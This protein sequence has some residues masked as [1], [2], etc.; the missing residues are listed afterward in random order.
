MKAIALTFALLAAPVAAQTT[1]L[2]EDFSGGAFPPVGWGE[3]QTGNTNGWEGDTG[4][5]AFHDDFQDLSESLL[6]SASMDLSSAADCWLHLGFG[7]RYPD[8]RFINL[9]QATVDGGLTFVDIHPMA[10][11]T[12]GGGQ[13]VHL[14]LAAFTGNADVRLA[15]YY[16]GDNS[17]EWWLEHV[18]VDDQVPPPSTYWPVEPTGFLSVDSLNEDFETLAGVVPIWM[19][20]NNLDAATRQID[21]EA[22]C[23]IG[24][25]A[26]CSEAFSGSYSLELGLD[27]A[28]TGPH[29]V[30]NALI[31][32]L[33]GRGYTGMLLHFQ[34]KQFNE[35]WNPDDGVFISQNGDIWYP[36]ASGWSDLA[37]AGE[38]T[39]V[40]LDLG[41]TPVDLN[42]DF[43]VAFAEADNYPF[44]VHDGVAIDDVIAEPTGTTLHYS[45]SNV[46]GGQLANIDITGAY[47]PG[48][49]V[50]VFL[51]TSGPGPVNTPYGPALMT[52]PLKL[53]G[54]YQ[55]DPNGEIHETVG[56]PPR[57][58]GMTIW[59]QVI[60]AAGAE[61]SWS[62]ALEIIV[63]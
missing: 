3:F 10:S 59:T 38:W 58:T 13:M 41:Q 51:S 57:F 26:P 9:V 33:S 20:V 7:Q 4:V 44:G 53:V 55:P 21:A 12:S 47:R 1:Y 49:L 36:V 60:E 40:T 62:N 22:W 48:S 5:G 19:G 15:F 31:M 28:V 37:P 32:G 16:E 17:N 30:S 6:V 27:P 42:G 34:V 14:D 24:Q 18:L 29:A 43:M 54:T 50:S 61:G 8:Y 11:L 25:M 45:L 35:E 23:N 52:P 46:V 39:S 63:Q 2:D 56:V